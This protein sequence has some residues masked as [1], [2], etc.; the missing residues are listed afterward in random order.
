[1]AEEVPVAEFKGIGGLEAVPDQVCKIDAFAKRN[2]D[3]RPQNDP[4]PT[5][6]STS[7]QRIWGRQTH[8]KDFLRISATTG[9]LAGLSR[10]SSGSHQSPD[11]SSP[12]DSVV[13]SHVRYDKRMCWR[14]HNSVEHMTF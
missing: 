6:P 14:V 3:G 5:P 7:S 10:G 12:R 13:F 2:L 4:F 8:R 1:M 11:M 9:G